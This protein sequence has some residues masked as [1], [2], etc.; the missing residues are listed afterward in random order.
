M[1]SILP[2][3]LCASKRP[4]TA[5][6]VLSPRSRSSSQTQR[7]R[8]CDGFVVLRRRSPCSFFTKSHTQHI[9]SILRREQRSRI[10]VIDFA[11]IPLFVEEACDR[12]SRIISTLPLFIMIQRKRLCDGFVVLRRRSMPV[13][14]A[15]AVRRESFGNGQNRGFGR[16]RTNHTTF[17]TFE[18]TFFIYTE[19][20]SSRSI[21][22]KPH[23][24]YFPSTS[25]SSPFLSPFG[26]G[27]CPSPPS[28]L[29]PAFL[30][31][32]FSFFRLLS[33]LSRLTA[34]PLPFPPYPSPLRPPVPL[35]FARPRLPLLSPPPLQTPFP[36]F[37]I[38]FLHFKFLS[39]SRN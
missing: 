10:D 25:A 12:P 14:I 22:P 35:A 7:K 30:S 23:L 33:F 24:P 4:A 1:R 8:L 37:R 2:K 27:I 38:F 18:I 15:V 5:L 19:P 11:K 13:C 31:S 36:F 34:H 39:D 16:L 21:F 28:S 3:F 17:R 29:F 26:A 9:T 32:I 20:H 6:R